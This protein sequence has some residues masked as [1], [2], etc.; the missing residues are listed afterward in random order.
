M[1]LCVCWHETEDLFLSL[2]LNSAIFYPIFPLMNGDKGNMQKTFW[3][4]CKSI[5][6]LNP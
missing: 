2:N 3:R 5:L 1:N 6:Y 4:L